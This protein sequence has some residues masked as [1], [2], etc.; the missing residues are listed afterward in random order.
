MPCEGSLVRIVCMNMGG[1]HMLCR[2]VAGVNLHGHG[3]EA[4]PL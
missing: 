1:G 3:L 4:D 2:R